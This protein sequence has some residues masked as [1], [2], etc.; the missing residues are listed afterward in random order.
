MAIMVSR[1]R[2][3]RSG[4]AR[5][6]PST[7]P[8]PQQERHTLG[9]TDEPE[10]QKSREQR[11]RGR[12]S[13]SLELAESRRPCEHRF[14]ERK[15]SGFRGE[16]EEGRGDPCTGSRDDLP[17]HRG[18]GPGKSAL[19]SI[20][21][22]PWDSIRAVDLEVRVRLWG[23]QEVIRGPRQRGCSRLGST[24]RAFRS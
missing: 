22:K 24:R 7:A 23:E 6:C 20:L 10:R 17:S 14:R 15:E 5:A 8:M 11:V 9:R 18:E 4:E 21:E 19:E 16:E 12:A 3:L 2:S 13:S 1:R